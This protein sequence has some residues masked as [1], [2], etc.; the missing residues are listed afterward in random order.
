[1]PSAARVRSFIARVEQEDYVGALM[2]FYHEDA[3]VQEN[4]GEIRKSR[5]ALVTHEMDLLVRYGRIPIRKVE[6]FAVNGDHVFINWIFELNIPGHGMRTLDEVAMQIW[7][8]DRIRSERY[9]Y[10]PA[11]I[12]I[13]T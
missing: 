6:R 13:V 10:D 4:H 1:M 12:R 3:I 5:D 2:H 11:Q 9:Y 7:D 8:G